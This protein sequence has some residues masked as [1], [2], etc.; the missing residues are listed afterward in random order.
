LTS[1]HV[2]NA[3]KRLEPS[4]IN[5]MHPVHK[6]KPDNSGLDPRIHAGTLRKREAVQD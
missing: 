2:P 3:A 6:I 5:V 4:R 1:S